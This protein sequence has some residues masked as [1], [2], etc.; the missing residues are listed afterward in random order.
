MVNTSM[1]M[2]FRLLYVLWT[3]LNL[4]RTEKQAGCKQP[5][6]RYSEVTGASPPVGLGEHVISLP[7]NI[8]P[9]LRYLHFWELMSQGWYLHRMS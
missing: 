3:C 7:Q 4:E 2:P 6:Q 9:A 1:D 5:D 8:L